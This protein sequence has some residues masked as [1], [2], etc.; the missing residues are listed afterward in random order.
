VDLHHPAK[1]RKLFGDRVA[2]AIAQVVAA[3][4]TAADPELYGHAVADKLL[5]NVLPYTVGTQ[6]VF[7]YGPW[8]GRSLTD[9]APNVMFSLATNTALSTAVTKDSV[10]FK[11]AGT[12][13]YVPVT[14]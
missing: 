11:S 6:T 3:Y 5:P 9:S 12:F 13:P 7:G 8:N 14:G 1:D 2:R 4:G 10:P